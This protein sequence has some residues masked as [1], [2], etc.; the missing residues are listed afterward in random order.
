M[1]INGSVSDYREKEKS[2]AGAVGGRAMAII[3]DLHEID[4][5]AYDG[6]SAREFM[7]T[8]DLS[9]KRSLMEYLKDKLESE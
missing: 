6:K 2:V 5:Y 4:E 8:T 1:Y 9:E 7:E 3:Y